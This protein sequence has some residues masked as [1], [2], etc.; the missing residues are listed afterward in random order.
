VRR[1]RSCWPRRATK[2]QHIAEA[3]GNTTRFLELLTEFNKAPDVTRT[4]LYLEAMEK[5]LPKLRK[6]VIR[7]RARSEADQP[8]PRSNYALTGLQ[9]SDRDLW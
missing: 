6:Y 8:A 1:G 5:I 7:L 2:D 3:T 9:A 4:R